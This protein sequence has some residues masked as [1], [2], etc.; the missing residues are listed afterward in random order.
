MNNA[1]HQLMSWS[2]VVGFVLGY[3][4]RYAWCLC[5]A[6]WLDKYRPNRDGSKHRRPVINATWLGGGMAL[7]AVAFSLYQAQHARDVTVEQAKS[8]RTLALGVAWD[9]YYAGKERC[10]LTDWLAKVVAPPQNIFDLHTTDP[11]YQDW[12]RGVNRGYLTKLDKIGQQR[13]TT[14]A[15]PPNK[16]PPE[17]KCET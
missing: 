13:V 14:V 16:P 7:S 10:A 2:L 17:M 11:A 8:T 15:H 9:Q 4:T 3:F 6:R 12:A 5:H 1:L